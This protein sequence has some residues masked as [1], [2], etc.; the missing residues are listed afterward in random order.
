MVMCVRGVGLRPVVPVAVPHNVLGHHAV[1]VV[2]GATAGAALRNARRDVAAKTAVRKAHCSS[3]WR[4]VKDD[5][6]IVSR[7]GI[8]TDISF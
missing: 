2:A 1:A 6:I 3:P 7:S 4:H 5:I 8:L